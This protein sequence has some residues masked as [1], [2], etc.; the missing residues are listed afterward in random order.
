MMS[1]TMLYPFL[2][3][4]VSDSID[5]GEIEK[6]FP[7]LP[8]SAPAARLF[9]LSAVMTAQDDAEEKLATLVSELATNAILHARTP[10][11]VKVRQDDATIRVSV[12]DQSPATPVRKSFGPKQPT[13]RGL[14]IVESFADRWGVSP[15][16]DGK[17]VWFEIDRVGA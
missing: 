5:P 14:L 13:G 16:R 12:S 11:K 4:G 9:V 7:P 10:F 15:S 1:L 8:E 2:F 3:L 6:V 17:T